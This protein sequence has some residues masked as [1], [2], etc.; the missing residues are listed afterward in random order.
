MHFVKWM[1]AA[2]FLTVHRYEVIV[3][4]LQVLWVMG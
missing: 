4:E 2:S 1:V 3:A